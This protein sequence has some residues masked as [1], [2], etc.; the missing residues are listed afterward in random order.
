V[1]VV[2]GSE[3]PTGLSYV[4]LPTI[5]AGKFINPGLCEWIALVCVV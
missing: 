1:F 5:R 2:P 3:V 4:R